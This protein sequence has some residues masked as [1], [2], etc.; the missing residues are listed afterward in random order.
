MNAAQSLSA[1]TED[2]LEA[3]F[4]IVAKNKVARSKD[5]AEK[6]KVKR[7]SVTG[8]LKALAEKGLVNY[9]PHSYI[10]LS[11]EGER[12]A[13]WVDDRH[14]VLKELFSEVLKLPVDETDKAACSMEHGVS[15][16][17][18]KALR[19]LLLAVR[20]NRELFDMLRK[21]MEA[22]LENVDCSNCLG[23]NAK[24]TGGNASADSTLNSL[25][26][27]EAGT[28]DRIVGNDTLKKRLREMGVTTG[29]EIRVIKSAP[30]N[31]PIEIKVRNYN[32]S[33]RREEANN[34]IIR[35]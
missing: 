19:S 2:Y 22:E 3:I 10:T 20:N 28:I 7:P 13:R 14:N 1:S 25:S 5:I 31:D 26:S 16:N 30:L 34:I 33:L 15:V 18:Y 4:T 6:L 27:G 29:Q 24:A 23:T 9:T 12:I 17:V 21:G 11:R 8:A 35:R 32:I